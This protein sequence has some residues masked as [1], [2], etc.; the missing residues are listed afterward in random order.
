MWLHIDEETAKKITAAWLLLGDLMFDCNQAKREK[1]S[2]ERKNQLLS[3]AKKL[4]PAPKTSKPKRS[5][6]DE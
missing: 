2:D 1:E 5:K 6:K 4:P 3:E